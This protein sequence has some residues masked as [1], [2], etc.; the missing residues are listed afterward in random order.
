MVVAVKTLKTQ[1]TGCL[2]LEA[3]LETFHRG[4][5]N[6]GVTEGLLQNTAN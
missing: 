3:D 4:K 5:L 2:I 6:V 1:G